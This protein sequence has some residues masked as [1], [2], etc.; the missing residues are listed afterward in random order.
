MHYL[1][2][3]VAIAAEVVATSALKSSAGFSRL[4]PSL[5]VITGYGTAFYCLSLVLQHLP[6]G[7]SYAIWS[8]LGIV[9]VV[10]VAMLLYGQRPDLPAMIGMALIM[11][12]VLVIQVFS[13]TSMH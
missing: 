11:L 9:G 7:T 4:L 5:L 13:K 10:L 6:L 12:G 8:G 1:L 3:F 2:L